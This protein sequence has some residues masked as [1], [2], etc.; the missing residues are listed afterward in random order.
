MNLF[1]FPFPAMNLIQSPA[2]MRTVGYAQGVFSDGRPFHAECWAE[3]G[4][5]HLTFFFSSVGI[6]HF[7]KDEVLAYLTMENVIRPIEGMQHYCGLG[8][9]SDELNQEMFSAT[10]TIGDEDHLFV[11][12]D[13]PLTGWSKYSGKGETP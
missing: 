13:M 5:T 7:K 8:I 3:S 9:L 12:S 1:K 2:D 6:N 11:D 4:A 10:V